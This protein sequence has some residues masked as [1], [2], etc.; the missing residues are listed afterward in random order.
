[1]DI[2]HYLLM[3]DSSENGRDSRRNW[4]VWSNSMLWLGSYSYR[5]FFLKNNYFINFIEVNTDQIDSIQCDNAIF[6]FSSRIFSKIEKNFFIQN[7][8]FWISSNF[9]P[10]FFFCLQQQWNFQNSTTSWNTFYFFNK[11][12][13][14]V[15]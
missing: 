3:R 11:I 9:L 14:R 12:I 5:F 2:H 10:M 7:L 13:E 15:F 1:M 6:L 8:E 4:T